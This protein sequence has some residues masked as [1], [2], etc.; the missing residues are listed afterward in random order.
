MSHSESDSLKQP[1]AAAQFAPTHWS[2]VLAAARTASPEADAAMESL[3][4]AYWFPVYAYLRRRGLARAEAEDLTQEFFTRRIMNG[5]IF[6]GIN[7]AAGKFRTWLLNSLKNLMHNEWDRQQAQKRGGGAP[8]LPIDFEGAEGQYAA[9]P[10]DDL[11][12]DKLYDVAWAWALLQRVLAQ[13]QSRSAEEGGA[14]QFGELKCFLPGAYSQQPYAEV[15]VRL[16]K[17]ENAVKV[18]V[19]RLRQDYGELLR[20]EVEQTVSNSAEAQE[21]LRYLMTV[22]S[23]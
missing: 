14:I 2:V 7:P 6:R 21:E 18:A 5:R 8:H 3:C 17:S 13:L 12:P 11:T 23:S 4:M 22:L 10:R 9:A 19:S 16:G 15:A 1:R 20:A